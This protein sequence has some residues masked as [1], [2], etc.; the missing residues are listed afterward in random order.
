MVCQTCR[1]V[2]G[3]ISLTLGPRIDLGEH[4]MLEHCD[5]VAMPAWF[6]L[7]LKRH[8]RALHEL[9][10][11]EW[12]EFGAWLPRLTRAMHAVTGC[13]LEYVVQLAEGPGFRHVH[14]H[15]MARMEDWPDGLR[16]PKVFGAFGAEP[17]VTAARQTELVEALPAEL[18]IERGPVA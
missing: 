11:A 1:A 4:W 3:E 18:E 17:S 6:V 13:E 7:V 10:D 9:R 2:S 8:A 5:P 12:E 14:V 15:L 16:G